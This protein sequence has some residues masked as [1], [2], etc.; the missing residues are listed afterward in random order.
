MATHSSV[1]AWRTPWTGE[2]GGLPSMGSHRVGHDWSDL[3]AS[4]TSYCL[5]GLVQERRTE[6]SSGHKGD[7][8]EIQREERGLRGSPG[9]ERVKRESGFVHNTGECGLQRLWVSAERWVVKHTLLTLGWSAG[10]FA[11]VKSLDCQIWCLWA[12]LAGAEMRGVWGGGGGSPQ[13]G[14]GAGPERNRKMVLC[15]PRELKWWAW[16]PEF[17]WGSWRDSYHLGTPT[18]EAEGDL[19]PH[20]TL[21]SVRELQLKGLY[22]YPSAGCSA[23]FLEQQS[24]EQWQGITLQG[25]IKQFH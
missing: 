3:A 8:P 10:V 2:P 5:P 20:L 24:W 1:L 11:P 19:E 12:C 18:Y 13:A 22:L 7:H 14:A 25:L 9:W 6:F 23:S 16:Q 4:R 15:E 21:Q 17:S